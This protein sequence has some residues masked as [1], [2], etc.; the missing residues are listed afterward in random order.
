MP[1]IT[2]SLPIALPSHITFPTPVEEQKGWGK[3]IIL[4]NCPDYCSKILCF[5]K[6]GQGSMHFHAEKHETWYVLEGAIRLRGIDMPTGDIWTTILK[7]G[8]MVDIPRLCAHQVMALSDAR[9]LEVS[10][11]HRDTDTFR[12]GKGDSQDKGFTTG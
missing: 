6:V 7:V 4:I 9:I 2:M 11:P 3:E 12:V 5:N 8:D 10:T 1:K